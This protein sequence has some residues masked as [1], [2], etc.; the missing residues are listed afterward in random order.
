MTFVELIINEAVNN[1]I[2]IANLYPQAKIAAEVPDTGIVI[3]NKSAYYVIQ[4]CAKLTVEYLPLLCYKSL[5][6]PIE[7]LKGK[8]TEQQLIEFINSKSL[9]NHIILELIINTKINM[10]NEND[11]KMLKENPYGE[12]GFSYRVNDVNILGELKNI[13][14]LVN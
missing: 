9:C 11:I 8:V 10:N 4:D 2:K 3:K 7:L 12:Y 5:N 1:G 13:F 6:N 14:Q